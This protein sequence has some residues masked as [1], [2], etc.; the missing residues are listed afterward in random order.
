VNETII[1]GN[2]ME[3]LQNIIA[4]S[5]DLVADG[6]SVLPWIAMDGVTISGK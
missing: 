6:G 4:I 3:I 2:I 5:A 1:S